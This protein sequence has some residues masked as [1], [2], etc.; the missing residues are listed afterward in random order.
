MAPTKAI[1]VHNQRAAEL[2][3]GALLRARPA[4]QLELQLAH[5]RLLQALQ[6]VELR[7]PRGL[8]VDVQA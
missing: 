5:L 6:A 2:L 4:G 7:V 1:V 3:R 8:F